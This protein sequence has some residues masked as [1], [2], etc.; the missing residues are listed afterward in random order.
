LPSKMCSPP[1]LILVRPACTE[2]LSEL[3]PFLRNRWRRAS[4]IGLF[5]AGK[6]TPVAVSRALRADLDDFLC[7]PFRDLDLFPRMQQLLQGDGET[8]TMPQAE[9]APARLCLEGIVGESKPFLQVVEH[10]LRVAPSDATILLAGETGTGK[11]LVARA[12][13]YSS[14]RRGKP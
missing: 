4:I 9:E 14:P 3:V 10:A 2:S 5:C 1:T 7:C 12:V 6:D 11:E 13:H 8:N